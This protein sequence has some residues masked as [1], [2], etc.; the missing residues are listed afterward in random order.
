MLAI[1]SEN[2]DFQIKQCQI[3][4]VRLAASS[5]HVVDDLP[6]IC[7][8]INAEVFK[9]LFPLPARIRSP[10]ELKLPASFRQGVITPFAKILAS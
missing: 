3:I 8:R 7:G 6:N 1:A 4:L 2:L 9:N 5:N 10:E